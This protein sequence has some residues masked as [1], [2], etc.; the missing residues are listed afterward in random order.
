MNSNPLQTRAHALTKVP[1]ITLGFW[2]IKI[3]ATTLGETG[4]D[5]VTMSLKLG[6]LIGTAIFAVI[7][8]GLV[9]GQIRAERFN[10]S[11]YWATIVATTTLGTTLAD[12]FDRSVGVGYPGG[13]VI[14]F[15]LLLASL[16]V[17]YKSEGTVAVQSVTTPK[18]EWFY[19]V[20]ILFSQ[21]L[22]TALGDWVAGS[23]EGG[24]GLGYEY[25]ALIFG[26][27]L[28]IVGALY[29]WSRLSRTAIFW[30]AFILTRPLGAT[31]GDLLD[32]PISQGGLEISRLYASVILVSFMALCV[33][34]LPQ[35]PAGRAMR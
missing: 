30:A 11:L 27:G 19:W 16:G 17:W 26:G 29:Y 1:Q 21:T 7:F 22:G 8:I 5:W 23:D 2:I 6:Y 10:A 15:A 12:F 25:G 32:K 31:L 14:V 4:G 34:F 24:L 35:R 20:T 33:I 18:A 13:V 9:A 3:A 28:L